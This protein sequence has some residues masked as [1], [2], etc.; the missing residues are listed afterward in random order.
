[1]RTIKFA[2]AAITM[3]TVFQTTA[4][5]EGVALG[6]TAGTLGLG[7]Q[8]AF[9]LQE[10]WNL[11]LGGNGLAYSYD[12]R[13]RG[14][15]YTVKAKM[16]SAPLVVDWFPTLRFP[17][18]ITGGIYGNFN[19]ADVEARADSGVWVVGN[20]TY[21]A[22]E[23]SRINGSVKYRAIA[24]YIGAGWGNAVASG[25]N[26]SWNVDIG[27]LYQGKPTTSYSVTCASG[28][29]AA[30]CTQLQNDAN[31][32]SREFDKDMNRYRVYPVAQFW[33]GKQF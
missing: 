13:E 22:N 19:K 15:D 27:L 14:V 16:A 32:E 11:R 26:W 24:P 31:L 5:A 33:V 28:I 8:V 9:S 1:M 4:R 29:S 21:G 23:V 7:A 3:V 2:V 6:L 10:Q 17:L 30:R 20:N 12:L 18:R 25:K